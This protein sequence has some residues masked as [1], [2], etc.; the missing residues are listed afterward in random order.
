MRTQKCAHS[1]RIIG[2]YTEALQRAELPALHLTSRLSRA[3]PLAERCGAGSAQRLLV[4]LELLG[5][6]GL[7]DAESRGVLNESALVSGRHIRRSLPAPLRDARA[8]SGKQS[9]YTPLRASQRTSHSRW[10]F[11]YNGVGLDVL[12]IGYEHFPEDLRRKIVDQYPRIN[13]KKD[14]ANAF[15]GG[16]EHKTQTTEA[17]C[18]EDIC[19]HFIRNYR[20]SNFYDQIQDSPFQNS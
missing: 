11:L 4:D 14:I 17:T 9:L 7:G 3:R 19:S 6:I 13:F 20:R 15:L 8:R 2:H 18:N 16:F 10:S 5:D 12:G 1:V